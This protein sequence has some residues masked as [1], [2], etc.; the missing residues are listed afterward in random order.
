MH[1]RGKPVR[2]NHGPTLNFVGRRVI[3]VDP[4]DN[5]YHSRCNN[6][7]ELYRKY[8]KYFSKQ[9]ENSANREKRNT[10][11]IHNTVEHNMA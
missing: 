9:P 8:L 11:R 4:R 10:A 6:N 2:K 7:G 1:R 5:R 3:Y